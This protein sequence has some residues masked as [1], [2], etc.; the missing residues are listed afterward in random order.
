[1]AKF[2]PMLAATIENEGQIQYPLFAS[3]KIDGIRALATAQGLISRSLKSL[4]NQH[5]Q[6]AYLEVIQDYPEYIGCDLEVTRWKSPIH[7]GNDYNSVQSAVMTADVKSD[8]CLNIFDYYLEPDVH[9]QSRYQQLRATIKRDL[10]L[11]KVGTTNHN[12]L[13]NLVT[14]KL[15]TTYQE[16]L[17][18]ESKWLEAGY[19]GLMVRSIDGPYKYGRS[20]IRQFYLAKLK[21]FLDSEAV[22]VGFEEQLKNNNPQA[23]DNLGNSKR[24]SHKANKVGKNTLG[25]LI[26]THPTFGQIQIGSGFDDVLRK[27]IWNNQESYLGQTVK[28]KYFPIGMKDKPRFP[29]FLGFRSDIDL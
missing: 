28:F 24:S 17:E 3:P 9:F 22:I 19:E 15:I 4:P 13:V 16:L 10:L 11:Q 27:Q 23:K 25:A 8:W 1:M 18:E 29:I 20:T 21:R 2:K 26:A 14:Q 7:P 6:Q 12:I 5:L